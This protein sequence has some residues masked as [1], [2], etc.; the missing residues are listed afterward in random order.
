VRINFK[1]PLWLALAAAGVSC[2]LGG[3]AWHHHQKS[4]SYD[5]AVSDEDTDPTYRYD[6]QRA[7][8]TIRDVQ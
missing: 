8:E 4:K 5:K 6:P 2:L 1:R 3:C 7:G